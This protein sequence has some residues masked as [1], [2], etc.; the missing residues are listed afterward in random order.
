MPEE[1]PLINLKDIHLPPS[2][3]I[4]PPAPGWW[5]VAVVL[6][7][8]FVFCGMWISR[9]LERR[10]PKT[11]A[12]RLLKNL[13]NQ[14]NNTKKSLEILRDLSQILRRVALTFCADEN[15]ASLHGS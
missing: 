11:E 13:Q 10:K 4:W 8:I 7:L 9:I 15:V 12:L 3:A 6:L 2:V 5:I 14:Q 1:N